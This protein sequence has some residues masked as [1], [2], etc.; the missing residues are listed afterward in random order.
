DIAS[1]THVGRTV[2]APLRRALIERDQTC[3]IPG[4]DVTEG[5]QIDHRII[6][7]V[8]NGETAL[9]NLARLC[10]HHHHLRHHGGFRLEGGPGDWQ[11][12]PPEKPPP[13]HLGQ[14]DDGDDDR[15]FK[16]E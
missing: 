14:P 1:V 16:L 12:L 10:R 9:W 15:L 7:V 11:W 3:V 2:R 13:Q 5:L 4:C 6:P 8:E